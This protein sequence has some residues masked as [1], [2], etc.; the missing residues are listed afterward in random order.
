MTTP[1]DA[2]LIVGFGGPEGPDDVMPFLENVTRGKPVPRERLLEVAEHYQHFGGVSPI[3]QQVRDLIRSLCREVNASLLL[4]SHDA[5][6]ANQMPRVVS[7]TELVRG[8]GFQP[9]LESQ[10]TGFKP[11]PRIR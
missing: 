3:N 7:L 4:V 11:V 10:D 2:L 9:V 5:D 6:I 8:T 1:Y